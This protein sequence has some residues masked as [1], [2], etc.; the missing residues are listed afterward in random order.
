[1]YV[2]LANE[3]NAILKENLL[4]IGVQFQKIFL[5]LQTITKRLMDYVFWN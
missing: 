5:S 4:L 3:L 1:M 2:F